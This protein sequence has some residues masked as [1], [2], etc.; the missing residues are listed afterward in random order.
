[1]SRRL[2]IVIPLAILLTGCA[3][4]PQHNPFMV[5]R[6]SFYEELRVVAMA[7]LRVPPDITEP[8]PVRSLFGGMLAA[9]LRDA[10]LTVISPE[11]TTVIW[12]SI[13]SAAGGT[14]D[15]VTG[16]ADQAKAA[17]IRLEFYRTMRDRY[18][19]NAVLFSAVGV[20]AAPLQGDVARWHGA[21]QN[22]GR[23][24]LLKA[25]LGQGHSGTIPAL[26]LFV[27]LSALDDADLYD[28][29]GGIRVLSKIG[30]FGGVEELQRAEMFTDQEKNTHAVRL[31][32]YPLL[33]RKLE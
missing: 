25:L 9:E 16:K 7:P 3:S 6:E 24:R 21:S 8:G 22:A 27:N 12:D 13:Q 5:P 4:R 2:I 33:G 32:L 17:S 31:A 30:P 15:P 14:Y 28:N 19:A 26:S 1:M 20:V 23:K 10:G 29:A 18:D 11:E